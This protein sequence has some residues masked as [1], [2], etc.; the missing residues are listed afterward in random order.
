[1]TDVAIIVLLIILIG[2]IIY[3]IKMDFYNRQKMFELQ[4]EGAKGQ[5]A[6]LK[7]MSWEDIKKTVNDIIS[8]NVSTYIITNGLQK[9]K[10][11]ELSLMWTMILGELCTRIDMSISDEIKRQ[12]FKSISQDYFSRFIKD[13]V[14]IT[15]IYQLENNKDNS[16][17]NRL[18]RIQQTQSNLPDITQRVTNAKK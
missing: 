4:I 1:M 2:V 16:V 11:D 18:S 8:F 17:N 15:I 10:N 7:D 14:Q 5:Q 12:A 13:S 3:Q 6:V 9:M